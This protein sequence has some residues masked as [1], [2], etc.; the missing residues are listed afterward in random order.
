MKL[1]IKKQRERKKNSQAELADAVGVTQGMVSQWES[2]EF[3]PRA[4]KLLA[5]SR[6]LDCSVDDL[7][8]NE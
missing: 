7:L 2:G 5:L 1:G 8:S 6:F 3:K 4:D